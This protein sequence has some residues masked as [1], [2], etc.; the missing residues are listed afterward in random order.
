MALAIILGH[1]P[2]TP[3]IPLQQFSSY[4]LLQ[5][6]GH[7]VKPVQPSTPNHKI[8]HKGKHEPPVFPHLENRVYHIHESE[9]S[10]NRL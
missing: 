10:V 3:F 9:I 8:S 2:Y 4:H 1:S 6:P 5:E 7:T